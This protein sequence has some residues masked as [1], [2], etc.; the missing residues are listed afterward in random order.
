MSA[1]IIQKLSE[2]KIKNINSIFYNPTY[3]DLLKEETLEILEGYEK[4]YKTNF[5]CQNVYT[6][7]FTGRSPKDKYIAQDEQTINTLWWNTKEYPNDNKPISQ[8]IWDNLRQITE[9]QLSNK[10]I[11]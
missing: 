7:K 2:I 11:L 5:N 4:S 1:L 8:K 6:G 10:K 9:R 3:E